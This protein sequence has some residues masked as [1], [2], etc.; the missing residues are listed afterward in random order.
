MLLERSLKYRILDLLIY[1]VLGLF[2]LSCVLPFIHELAVSLSGRTVVA[3]NKVGLL[4]VD[5]TWDNYLAVSAKDQFT[6][7]LLISI[8]RVL[9]AVPATL[10]IV[11]ATAYPLAMDRIP[12]P[13]RRLFLAIMVFLN[14]FQVGLIPRF[15]SYKNL[16]LTDNF[17]VFILPLLLNTFNVILVMNFF[18][19]IPYEMVEAAMLD[20]A[21]HWDV[22]TRVMMPLS[23]PILATISL[24]TIV[25]HWNSWFDGIIYMRSMKMWPL[26]SYLYT[27]LTNAQLS[28]EFAG[29]RFSGIFPNVS[30]DGAEAA[31]VFFAVIPVLIIYP[32]LQ[33]YI[34]SGMTLGSVKE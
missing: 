27:M 2:F 29:H 4:P 24:F 34:I 10:L 26:Q 13:G 30:P 14:L 8:L 15:L 18:R 5:F 19:G 23:A 31:M 1:I 9:I 28:S 6:Q 25:T 11:V 32:L 16:G 33:R 20:G 22:L 17:A 21:T 7:S 3:A 12:M